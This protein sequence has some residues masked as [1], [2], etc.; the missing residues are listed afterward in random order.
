[1]AIYFEDTWPS[2]Y[3]IYMAIYIHIVYAAIYPMWPYGHI[4][5]INMA[6]YIIYIYIYKKVLHVQ[7]RS[8]TCPAP[9]AR[10]TRANGHVY[11][12]YMTTYVTYI[13]GHV[14]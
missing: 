2:T 12:I 10:P 9:V 13:Y 8:P 14:Y 3:L 6:T 5:L 7:A 1:M 4:C 11:L